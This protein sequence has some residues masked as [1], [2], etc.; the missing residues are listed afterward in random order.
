MRVMARITM[1]TEQGSRAV[2]DGTI[3]KI[4]QST[5]ERWKPEAMYFTANDGKRCAYIIFDMADSADM[6]PFAEPFFAGLAADVEISPVMNPEDL[7]KGLSR[8]G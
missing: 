5:V 6:P 2:S 7:Q 4:I 8:L 3:G 1:Q